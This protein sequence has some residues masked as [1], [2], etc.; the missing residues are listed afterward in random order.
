MADYE[1]IFDTEIQQW[2]YVKTGSMTGPFATAAE[3][4]DE[5]EAER[6]INA[7]FKFWRGDEATK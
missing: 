6:D 7:A 2:W 1:I 4:A 3:A 5:A